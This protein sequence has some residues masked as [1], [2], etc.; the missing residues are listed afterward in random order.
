MPK[1][2]LTRPKLEVE[3]DGKTY[4]MTYPTMDELQGLEKEQEDEGPSIARVRAVLER[5][6]LPKEVVGTLDASLVGAIMEE[7]GG[8]SKKK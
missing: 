4:S 8:G 6:G 7:L 5:H 3:L 2:K 1:L